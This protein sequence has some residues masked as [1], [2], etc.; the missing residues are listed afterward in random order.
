MGHKLLEVI[1]MMKQN[2]VFRKFLSE[3]DDSHVSVR[4][5][6]YEDLDDTY[7]ITFEVRGDTSWNSNSG[8]EFSYSLAQGMTSDERL[9]VYSDA[10]NQ[11]EGLKVAANAL[12]D[13]VAEEFARQE[14]VVNQENRDEKEANA[15]EDGM[16]KG[17]DEDVSF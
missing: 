5:R 7:N 6:T 15:S 1:A 8:A 17:Y 10:V 14:Q 12:I 11:M 3:E 13:S 4:E 9:K 2:V 16:S